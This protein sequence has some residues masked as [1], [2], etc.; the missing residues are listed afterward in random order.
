MD[1]PCRLELNNAGSWKLLGRVDAA[2]AYQTDLVMDAAE[3][4]VQALHNSEDP[5]RCATLR[6]STDEAL[7]EVLARWDI[8]RGWREARTGAAL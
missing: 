5:K 7:P 8:E 2:D 4:L 3:A 1:K 6:I